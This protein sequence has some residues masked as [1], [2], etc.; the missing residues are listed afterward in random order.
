MHAFGKCQIR[1]SLLSGVHQ[2]TILLRG[3]KTQLAAAAL[4]K[5]SCEIRYEAWRCIKTS[6]LSTNSSAN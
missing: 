2:I 4:R 6:P 5:P 3:L 1:P